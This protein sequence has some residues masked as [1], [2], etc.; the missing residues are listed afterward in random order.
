MK[1]FEIL[2]ISGD[3]G[4]RVFGKN[5]QEIFVNSAVGMYSLITDLSLIKERK[6]IEISVESLTN[7]GLFVSWLNELIF[8]F[9][10]YGFV[11]KQIELAELILQSD[12][13][14]SIQTCTIKAILTGE[15]FDPERHERKLLVKAATYHKLRIEKIG[16]KWETDVVFDI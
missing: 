6:T 8:H 16:D 13:L 10:T 3:I 14:S 9:D 2:D 5:R 7:D 1:Q 15:D 4:L 11:G 12:K